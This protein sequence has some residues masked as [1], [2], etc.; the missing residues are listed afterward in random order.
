[1]NHLALRLLP[2]ALNLY[3]NRQITIEFFLKEVAQK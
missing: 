1:L 3:D 2:W